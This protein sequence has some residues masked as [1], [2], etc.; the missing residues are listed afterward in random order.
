MSIYF[1]QPQTTTQTK[2]LLWECATR[3]L[4]MTHIVSF[5]KPGLL[6]TS[7]RQSLS[8]NLRC[9]KETTNIGCTLN[10]P[11]HGLPFNP[12]NNIIHQLFYFLQISFRLFWTTVWYH[13][14]SEWSVLPLAIRICE[15]DNIV[16]KWLQRGMY[17]RVV[18]L[19][20]ENIN[21]LLKRYNYF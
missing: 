20:T 18:F 19:F 1:H 15:V 9:N 17:V 5:F 8:D 11:F 7:G 3:N 2:C 13:D 6:I 16:F 10:F 14:S 4:L 21:N 12:D